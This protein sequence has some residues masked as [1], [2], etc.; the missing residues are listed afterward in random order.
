MSW[1]INRHNFQTN[2][3]IIIV[4]SCSYIH[5]VLFSSTMCSHTK[6]KRN[7]SC[8]AV[9]HWLWWQ[10]QLETKYDMGLQ[11][12]QKSQY[13]PCG[14]LCMLQRKG[15][16]VLIHWYLFVLWYSERWTM[17]AN[18]SHCQWRTQEFFSGGG[19]QQIQLR[20]ED[21]TGIWGAVAP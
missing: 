4:T 21:R 9:C 12:F 2:I 1:A 8:L 15:K 17:P 6:W 14:L 3:S 16:L 13:V 18:L 5:A 20:T 19:V 11:V 10:C 7:I